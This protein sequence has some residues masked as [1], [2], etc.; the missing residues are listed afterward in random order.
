MP[1]IIDITGN[2]Y[3]RLTV[4]RFSH[5]KDH[6]SFW[7]CRCDCG[8]ECT[9]QG[10]TLKNGCTESCGCFATESKSERFK[11][12][13]LS[14]AHRKKLSEIKKAVPCKIAGWNKGIPRSQESTEKFSLKMKGRKR[15]PFSAEWRKN[16]GEAGR[17]REM[18]V[19]QRIATSLRFKGEKC[20]L[21]K[22]GITPLNQTIRHSMEYVQWRK[23][24]FERD[25]W[26]CNQCHKRGGNMEA[27]HIKEFHLYPDFRFD[28]NN[29]ETLCKPCHDSTKLNKRILPNG[30]IA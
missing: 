30:K 18:S 7:E 12:K 17:G 26:T 3:G 1:K 25:D 4:L 27:H 15:P 22:G 2:R 5:I 10:L 19:E 20:H 11:G 16:I 9:K 6:R 21:W 14:V 8:K 13:P 29:G 24:V 28:I 23:L